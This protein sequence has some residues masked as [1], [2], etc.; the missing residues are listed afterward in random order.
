MVTW[1]VYSDWPSGAENHRVLQTRRR[2]AEREWTLA[3]QLWQIEFTA[4]LVELG[5][6]FDRTGRDSPG[7]EYASGWWPLSG[8]AA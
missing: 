6:K 4:L 8:Q 3:L 5:V 1:G 7:D 2:P